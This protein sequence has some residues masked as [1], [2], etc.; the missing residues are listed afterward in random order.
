[1]FPP[2][3]PL[4]ACADGI[5][6]PGTRK[7]AWQRLTREVLRPEHP[8]ELHAALHAAV[9]AAWDE[10]VLGP[11]PVW[12]PAAADV[13]GTNLLGFMERFDVRRRGAAGG[14]LRAA[15]AGGGWGTAG[16]GRRLARRR[17]GLQRRLPRAPFSH[18]HAHTTAAA[19]PPQPQGDIAWCAQR[20][21]RPAA[22]WRLL[23]RVSV[24]NP[25]AFWAALLRELGVEFETPPARMLR[26]APPDAP[27]G[28]ARAQRGPGAVGRGGSRGGG[29]R[30]AG[31]VP[32][33]GRRA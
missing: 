24:A 8:F 30:E 28:C 17:P 3:C 15:A 4:R 20:S 22:D 18:T 21:G 6:P 10:G 25:E 26:E 2:R 32:C 9:F 31:H 23:Q 7:Q 16:C 29:R 19:R 13:A 5:P 27:D 33:P 1:M 14:R 11:P 12:L